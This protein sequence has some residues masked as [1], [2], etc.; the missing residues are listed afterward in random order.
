MSPDIIL[1]VVTVLM[2]LL[3]AAVSLHPPESL[4]APGKWWVKVSYAAAF[5][6]L[7][8]IAVVCVIKQSKETAV[9]NQNLTNALTNLGNSAQEIS[10]VTSLNTA[11]Q[12]RLLDQSTHISKLAAESFRNIIG[13]DSFPYI[14]PQP[15]AYPGPVPLVIWDH[16][17]YMLNGVTIK[18]RKDTDFNLFQPAID[19]GVLHAGWGKQ[20]STVIQPNPESNDD[21]WLVEMYTQ[22]GYFTEII[23]FRKSRDGISFGLSN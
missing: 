7:G 3:G 9:A 14:A 16:G 15:A 17:K 18:I 10:R 1:G 21:I 6:I 2:A 8:A 5:V 20:L 19:V 23:H 22:S 11:L 4:H 12:E 13:V